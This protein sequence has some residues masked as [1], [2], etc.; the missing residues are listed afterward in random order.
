MALTLPHHAS[1]ERSARFLRGLEWLMVPVLMALGFMLASFAVRNSDFWMHLATGRLIAQGDYSFGV[2]PFSHASAGRYWVNHAWLFDLV[3]Y[4]LY[5]L[6]PSHSAVVYFKAG[7][8]ALLALVMVLAARPELRKRIV[9]G[10]K[11]DPSGWAAAIFV[12][13]AL[14]AISPRLLMQPVLVSYLFVGITLMVL[15][16]SRAWPS[17]GLPVTLSG[18]FVVWVNCDTWFFLGPLLVA[19]FLAGELIQGLMPG[20]EAIDK[21]R[22]KN[23]CL[24]LVVGLAACL[25]SPHHYHV[26][27]VLPTELNANVVLEMQ[28]ERSQ[29]GQFLSPLDIVYQNNSGLG[30]SIGGYSYLVLAIV[31]L[32]S[33]IMTSIRPRVALLLIWAAFLGLSLINWR[34]IPFFAV[35]TA[36]IIALNVQAFFARRPDRQF[37]NGPAPE[38]HFKP[39]ASHLSAP[40]PEKTPAAT[41][42]TVDQPREAWWPGAT[43]TATAPPAA[44]YTP[45][46]ESARPAPKGGVTVTP[47]SMLAFGSIVGRLLTIL[48]GLLALGAAYPGWLHSTVPANAADYRVSWDVTPNAAYQQL[49]EQ[50]AEWRKEGKL[51]AGA[52]GMPLQPW[53]GNY[54][55]WFAP[56]E[57]GF[58]DLRFQLLGDLSG[59]YAQ[60]KRGLKELSERVEQPADYAAVLRRHGITHVIIADAGDDE[61]ARYFGVM[62]V[63]PI[64]WSLWFQ[65]GKTAIFGWHEPDPRRPEPPTDPLRLDL[66]EMAFGPKAPRVPAPETFGV[67]RQLPPDPSLEIKRTFLDFYLSQPPP[68]AAPETDSAFMYLRLQ[69]FAEGTANYQSLRNL[70]VARIAGALGKFLAAPGAPILGSGLSHDPILGPIPT[71]DVP[72]PP[73]FEQQRVRVMARFHP[74]PLAFNVL[75]ARDALRG[76]LAQPN[77]GRAHLIHA[78]S[79]SM[80]PRVGDEFRSIQQVVAGRQALARLTTEQQQSPE[81]GQMVTLTLLPLY[82][83]HKLRGERDLALEC[84]QK[85]VIQYERFPPPN[86]SEDDLPK[87]L[88]GMNK[89][90]DRLQRDVEAAQDNFQI[91]L[92]D[93]RRRNRPVQE[94][95]GLALGSGLVREAL[96]LLDEESLRLELPTLQLLIRTHL[97]LGQPEEAQEVLRQVPEQFR[98][99]FA[100]FQ[101][102]I[103]IATGDYAR[104]GK[105]LD[106]QIAAQERRVDLKVKSQ[107]LA[108]AL[109]RLTLGV[110][111]TAARAV[112]FTILRENLENM[113]G[114]AIQIEQVDRQRAEMQAMRAMLALEEGD[115]KTARKYFKAAFDIQTRFKGD[116]NANAY[117]RALEEYGAK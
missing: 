12:A 71:L 58:L 93:A 117:R 92:A 112:N 84:L 49:A 2:D 20:S 78:L 111:E 85:A 55:A 24:T 59:D 97:A 25:V 18:L 105:A 47:E 50:I 80:L 63:N 76:V 44:R 72:I 40:E 45:Y 73:A 109:L 39:S 36:P 65:N 10:T 16:S 79:L 66:V 13:I 67:T 32:G 61:F 56:E 38:P 51:P 104:A 116:V 83:E 89:E 82:Q 64:E 95:V 106:E 29:L 4:K 30:K 114:A 96:K 9:P 81:L 62:L 27:T 69:P 113:F 46:P 11:V 35:V 102:V 3:L 99:Q 90:L 33:F 5:S 53:L 22:I 115:T 52:K 94:Q 107:L 41:A 54:L 1:A 26:F 43:E 6:A 77:S 19:L 74:L 88:A 15:Q 108:A 75:A 100:P 57:R 68:P 17:W 98:T 110:P 8:M 48:L 14:L 101:T 70:A 34:L 86:R 23:L 87:E 42:F 21:T 91:S 31:G 28:R 103:W 37:E 7:L 60:V